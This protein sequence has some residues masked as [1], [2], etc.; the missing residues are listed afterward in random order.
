[1]S[2]EEQEL[3]RLAET[4]AQA[5]PPGF[6]AES[7]VRRIRRRRAWI[8]AAVSAAFLAAAAIA[9]AIPVSLSASRPV[10]NQP[11]VIP[12]QLSF[13]VMV[14]GQSGAQGTVPR[15][16]IAPGE[17]ITINVGVTVPAHATVK[18]L[19]LG[20]ASGSWGSGPDGPTGVSPTLAARTRAPL[21]P[22]VQQFTLHW[23]VPAGLPHGK[24]RQL[25][26]SWAITDGAATRAIAEFVVR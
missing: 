23:V 6:T 8:N 2:I 20:I 13:T 7:L 9:I 22:G 3:R 19:W 26:A 10:N 21:G 1:M 4:A 11:A 5:S 14:N 24:S 18:G 16:V 25:V 17:D 12:V 15:F